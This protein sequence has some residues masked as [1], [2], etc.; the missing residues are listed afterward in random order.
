MA[1]P[2]KTV[3]ENRLEWIL[4]VVERGRGKNVGETS[5]PYK[6]QWG[7]SL[8]VFHYMQMGIAEC[9]LRNE[10]LVFHDTG[11]EQISRLKA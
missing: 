4:P 5:F 11:Q 10:K 3:V 6:N 2:K 1:L 7:T 9:R 8:I